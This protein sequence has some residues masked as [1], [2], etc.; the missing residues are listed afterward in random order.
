SRAISTQEE[1]M[2][3][4]KAQGFEVTQATVSRDIKELK[5]VKHA[6]Y[7]GNTRYVEPVASNADVHTEKFRTIFR[8]S[9]ISVKTAGNL[10]VL[11]CFTGM[12]NAACAALDSMGFEHIVGTIAGDDTIFCAV[13]SQLDAREVVKTLNTIVK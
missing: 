9:V 3:L 7:N 13:E 8:E 4:L 10:V 6:D 1:L 5:L 11:K 12:G 2:Q